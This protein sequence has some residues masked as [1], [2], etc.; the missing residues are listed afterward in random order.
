M[1]KIIVSLT[2]I[3]CFYIAMAQKKVQ[4]LQPARISVFK[5]GTYFI[6]REA[7]VTVNDQTFY[8]PAPENVLLGTYWLAVSKEAPLHS[9]VIK[10]DTLKIDRNADHLY[11]YLMANIGEPVTLLGTTYQNGEQKKLS[12]RLLEFNSTNFTIKVALS[13]G[14]IVIANAT[15]FNQLE[16]NGK[17]AGK[18]T[19]DSITSV[20]KVNLTKPVNKTMAS[21]ISLEKGI[22]WY[23]SYLFT[24]INDKEAKLE[25]KAT[26]A[27]G[28]TD[29][30][31]TPVDIIIGN[32]EMFYGKQLDPVCTGYF[33]ETVLNNRYDNNIMQLNY[34]SLANTNTWSPSVNAG[35]ANTEADDTE[36]DQ[37]EGQKSE[38]L[39]YY[40]L[41]NIDL[42]RN[43]RVIVPVFTASV[44][45]SEIYTADLAENSTEAT[46]DNPVEVYH[47]YNINNS[48]AAPFTTG[49]VFVLSQQSQPFAQSKI[50]YT[51]V[52]GNA[53]I[54]LSKA[55]DVQVKNE[56]EEIKREKVI[57]ALKTTYE[58]NKITF[59][60]TLKLSN[61]QAKTITIKVTKKIDGVVLM[62][63]N[64]G[65]YKKPKNTSNR[66]KD[67]SSAEWEITLLAGASIQLSYQYYTIN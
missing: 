14:N 67:N 22:Q 20:A 32:P 4:P 39:Y 5:N 9:V 62:A 47:V 65:K 44:N 34:A 31:N 50:N 54:R 55:I 23:P 51:P 33:N 8:I 10:T 21:T 63:D 11:G 40:Q 30:I 16:L 17:S 59:N 48:T 36:E 46:E 56:E 37:K 29:F 3:C 38:D 61:Y 1:K 19:G 6:K 57:S 41:G 13:N 53:E 28:N 58:T 7:T 45:Y 26:I 18:F 27:N 24:P 66:K 2:A 43:A 15:D 12:G 49:A 25:M 60:G 42:E 35:I 64:G 52:K